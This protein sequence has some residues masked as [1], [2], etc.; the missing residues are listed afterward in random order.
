M[1]FLT[2]YMK[3]HENQASSYVRYHSEYQ[4]QIGDGTKE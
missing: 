4:I 3:I 2:S 1:K